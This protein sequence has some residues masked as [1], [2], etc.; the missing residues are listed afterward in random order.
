MKK[1]KLFL[2]VIIC[3]ASIFAQP[4]LHLQA[5]YFAPQVSLKNEIINGPLISAGVIFNNVYESPFF[6]EAKADY[7]F[8]SNGI[9]RVDII[10]LSW[11]VYAPI[12]SNDVFCL[13]PSAGV[14]MT[15][16]SSQ[17]SL[18]SRGAMASN[19]ALTAGGQVGVSIIFYNVTFTTEYLIREVSG[20]DDQF[21]MGGLTMS[22]GY[23][24][25]L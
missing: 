4:S 22:L 25:E 1:A 16:F 8:N 11:S 24:F 3:S 23:I 5:G 15:R 7:F 14:S 20:L 9:D 2:L 19:P 17:T 6:V 21:R 18:A 10:S 12:I 13:S